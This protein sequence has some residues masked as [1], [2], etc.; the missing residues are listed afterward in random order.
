M[1]S[2]HPRSCATSS[3]PASN[4][5]APR[6]AASARDATA[7]PLS[8]MDFVDIREV[9]PRDGLQSEK[10][11]PVEERV[12]LITA[13]IDSGVRHIEACSF[14]SPKAV[15]SMAGA[16]DVM[17]SVPRSPDVRYA[18]LVPNVKGA[19]LALAA[20]VD[21]VT[22]TVSASETYNQKNVRRTIEESVTEVR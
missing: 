3:S 19:E 16:A 5:P 7:C 13:L 9:G 10:Q 20:G 18:A 15:P 12:Q 11:L 2:W 22:V 6:T 21:E 17:A 1:P 4:W 8:E 14:V